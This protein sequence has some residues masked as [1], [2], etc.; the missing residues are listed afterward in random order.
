MVASEAWP[1][2][3]AAVTHRADKPQVPDD[4]PKRKMSVVPLKNSVPAAS[5]FF[6]VAAFRV[7]ADAVLKYFNQ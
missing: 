1:P 6:N 4:S 7:A 2:K 3:A 5:S